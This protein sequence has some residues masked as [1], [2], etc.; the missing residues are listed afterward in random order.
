MEYVKVAKYIGGNETNPLPEYT[1]VPTPDDTY[2]IDIV[3]QPIDPV[4]KAELPLESKPD[5]YDDKLQEIT[6]S[7]YHV[8]RLILRTTNYKVDRLDV[9][10]L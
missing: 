1:E 10:A 8:D 5:V 7:I 9:L 4:T 3:A 6:V 2:E